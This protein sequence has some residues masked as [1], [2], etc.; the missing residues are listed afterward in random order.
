MHILFKSRAPLAAELNDVARM[1]ALFVLRRF[2]AR[3]PQATIQLSDVNG[4]RGGVDK[5]CQVELKTDRAGAV[6][7]TAVADQW[8]TALNNVLLRASRLLAKRFERGHSSRRESPVA[9]A[10]ER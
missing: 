2:A 3:I 10:P 5:R 4:P 7:V 8:R 1:R 9:I 6:V